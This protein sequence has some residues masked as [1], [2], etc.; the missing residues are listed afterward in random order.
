MAK[1][2]TY[3]PKAKGWPSFYTYYPEKMVSMNNR[4]YSFKNGELYIHNENPQTLF[5]DDAEISDNSITGVINEAPHEVKHFK[6]ISLESTG[7]WS[8]TLDTDLQSGHVNNTDFDKIEGEYFSNIYLNDTVADTRGAQGIGHISQITTSPQYVFN[9]SHQVNPMVS[10]GDNIIVID[11][12][13]STNAFGTVN[14]YDNGSVK[15]SNNPVGFEPAVGD[16]VL[17]S[18][19]GRIE[20]YGLKGYYMKYVLTGNFST[21]EQL[22]SVGTNF[23]K[24]YA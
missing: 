14:T 9:F 20:A 2:L 22:Y 8:V 1:T 24:S 15:I 6:T 5:H 16:F 17:F 18:K 4:F 3:S 23:F 19:P 10:D 7:S 13:G 21:P 11:S 12:D